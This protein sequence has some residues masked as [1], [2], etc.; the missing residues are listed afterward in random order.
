MHPRLSWDP[1][2][3]AVHPLWAGQLDKL[4]AARSM[5]GHGGA[6]RKYIIHVHLM[7]HPLWKSTHTC[8]FSHFIIW[9]AGLRSH[10]SLWMFSCTVIRTPP[11]I[12]HPPHPYSCRCL[13]GGSSEFCSKTPRLALAQFVFQEC[14]FFLVSSVRG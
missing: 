4:N 11:P 8:K 14:E 10:M 2:I 9:L 5:D 12:L 7:G 6:G 3:M 13:V 1:D